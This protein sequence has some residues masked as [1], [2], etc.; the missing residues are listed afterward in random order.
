MIHSMQVHSVQELTT[1]ICHLSHKATNRTIPTMQMWLQPECQS[2]VARKWKHLFW[3]RRRSGDLRGLFDRWAHWSKYYRSHKL[4]QQH[5]QNKRRERFRRITRNAA[6]AAEQR[7]SKAL[8]EAV[9]ELPTQTV[10]SFSGQFGQVLSPRTRIGN[11]WSSFSGDLW[12]RGQ[13]L[14]HAVCTLDSNR[15]RHC[16][17]TSKD[18]TEQ[19]SCSRYSP[20]HRHASGKWPIYRHHPVGK[21]LTYPYL[22]SRKLRLP[23]T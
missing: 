12:Q 8:Y 4:L 21:M 1:K 14:S 9:R 7:N 2:L 11:A 19:S 3:A 16:T 18:Q 10:Y 22:Q 15:R 13:F 5:C 17:T 6:R 23:M 20:W